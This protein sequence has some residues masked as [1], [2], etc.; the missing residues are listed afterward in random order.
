MIDPLNQVS[1]APEWPAP[2]NVHAAVTLRQGGVSDGAWSSLNLGS[3]VGDDPAAVAE[4]RRRLVQAL[5]LPAEPCWLEQVHGTRIADLDTSE[6]GSVTPCATAA[7]AETVI[8]PTARTVET[9]ALRQRADGAVTGRAGVVCVIMTADCLP[10]LLADRRGRRIAAAHAGWR[11]LL[12]GV[13]QNAVQAL[14]AAPQDV[15]AWLGPAISQPAFEVGEEVRTAFAGRG[16]STDGA[17]LPNPRGRWQADLYALA[18]QSLAQAGVTSVYGGSWCTYTD[19]E[20]FFS[21]RRQAPCGRMATLI[22]RD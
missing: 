4:N 16:F 11:G 20:R 13:L 10:V 3:H 14:G 5:E 1:L 2:S 15:V 21:H 9:V 8:R 12:G 18:R 17:F 6:P 22:W 19:A 7:S